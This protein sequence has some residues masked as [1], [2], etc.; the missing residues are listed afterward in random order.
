M[1]TCD[2]LLLL[3]VTFCYL[4]LLV[5]SCGYLW[6]LVIT[7]GY[8]YLLLLVVTCD[9]LWFL[10]FTC[11]VLFNDSCTD[12]C[13]N[14]FPFRPQVLTIYSVF[15]PYVPRFSFFLVK[16]IFN[17]LQWFSNIF[18]LKP[19][20]QTRGNPS[21][22]RPSPV[23]PRIAGPPGCGKTMLARAAAV[24]LEEDASFFHGTS[25]RIRMDSYGWMASNDGLIIII[26]RMIRMMM[27]MVMMMLGY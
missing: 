6:L 3:V 7:F 25:M 23:L 18:L 13:P 16:P 11:Q 24:E 10:T 9:Y 22:P 5:I 4:R 21:H 12:V 27:M 14:I 20:F 1:V 26:I 19:P 8:R 2:Y 17:H 15:C